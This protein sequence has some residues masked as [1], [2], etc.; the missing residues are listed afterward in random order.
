MDWEELKN[1][2]ATC[3]DYKEALETVKPISWLKTVVAF[4]NTRGGHIVF[5]VEDTTHEFLGLDDPQATTTKISELISSRVEP[6]PSYM[7]TQVNLPNSDRKCLDLDVTNG[8]NYP[9]RYVNKQDRI[10]FVRHGDR[11]EKATQIELN[12]LVLKG[13]N[14]TFDS[15]PTEYKLSDV[16]FTLLAATFKKVTGDDFDLSKDLLSMKLVSPDGFVTNAG[17]LL[18]DQGYLR[19]SR[20]VCTRWKGNSKGSIDGDALDDSE[21]SDASMITLLSNAETFVKNNSKKPWTIKGMRREENSDYPFTAVREVLVNALIH[22]DYQIQGAEVHV[23]MFDDR[24]EISSPGGMMNGSRIQDLNLDHVP[25]MRRNEIISDIFGR[26]HYMERRGS[27]IQRIMNSYT[28]FVEQ[29][30]FYS[31]DTQFLVTMPNRGVAT[32]VEKSPLSSQESPLQSEKSPLS[33]QES[34]LQTEKNP[35]SDQDELSEELIRSLICKRAN[36][37][38]KKGTTAKILKLYKKYGFNYS[39]NRENVAN[40]LGIGLSRA[41][42]IINKCKQNGIMRM[43]KR[44][45]YYF[46]KPIEDDQEE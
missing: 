13:M 43:E 32:L 20:V 37:I 7:L 46:Q 18:C 10:T 24:L 3:L 30:E 45:V 39:F 12:N 33:D 23:D 19:Q 44:G 1:V 35:F 22:R 34:P 36:R 5:G 9:Y 27:G 17:L 6:K 8:P 26:L 40:H 21:Y 15:L 11:S 42:K 4:A 25:S 29:P 16:S 41:S 31:D 2:E 14:K 28:D 38:F